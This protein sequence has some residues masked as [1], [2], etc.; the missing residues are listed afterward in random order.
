MQN[1][2]KTILGIMLI[3]LLSTGPALTAVADDIIEALEDARQKYQKGE[4]G[5]AAASLDY[6]AQL[7]RQKSSG[8]LAGFL[9]QALPGW[10]ASEVI[11]QAA[12]ASLFG[13]GITTEQTFRKNSSRVH[14]KIMADSPLSQSM[15]IMFS[16]PM[17]AAADGGKL[18]KIG[19]ERAIVKYHAGNRNGS[20]SV[21]VNNRILVQIEG[22]NVDRQDLQ[23]YIQQVDFKRLSVL[24]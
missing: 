13:G 14:A 10:T 1:F 20:I 22:S 6:A 18:E 16:N 11:S 8:Q 19:G 5:P 12:G 9:P 2:Q 3:G 23:E 7:I 17:L 21:L 24:P 4:L 15:S